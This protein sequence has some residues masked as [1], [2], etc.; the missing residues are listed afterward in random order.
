MY[1]QD[2]LT[3][4]L[5]KF[6]KDLMKYL[7]EAKKPFLLNWSKMANFL[8]QSR[9]FSMSQR[10]IRKEKHYLILTHSKVILRTKTWSKVSPKIDYIVSKI[11]PQSSSLT[12]A[13]N[14]FASYGETVQI[15][16]QISKKWVSD[17]NAKQE[18]KKKT[19]KKTYNY[20][21]M[22]THPCFLAS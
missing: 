19:K 6:Y 9:V 5:S 7:G 4:Q 13:S 10:I 2:G 14:V 21:R 18:K 8:F 3:M 12:L 17:S 22:L 20:N 15:N 16:N 1:V 11:C